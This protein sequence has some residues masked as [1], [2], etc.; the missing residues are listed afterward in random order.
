MTRIKELENK[1]EELEQELE[2]SMEWGGMQERNSCEAENRALE[3]EA[4]IKNN[5]LQKAL[6]DL[7]WYTRQGLA[8]PS[9][10]VF[11]FSELLNIPEREVK[12]LLYEHLV[13]YI[14]IL[15]IQAGYETAYDHNDIL[16]YC[17][18]CNGLK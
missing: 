8:S 17:Q 1:I 3:A 11:Q 6:T 9:D 16:K 12:E 10:F 5:P 7:V 13:H 4:L 18:Y 14:E 15:R 2:R